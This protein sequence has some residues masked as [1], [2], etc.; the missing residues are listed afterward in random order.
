MD[1]TT[2]DPRTSGDSRRGGRP[3]AGTDPR[4]RRQ[5]MDGAGRVFSALGF[6]A[7]SMNDVAREAEVSKATLYV[8]FENKEQLFTAI[9]AER[10]DRNISDLI[11]YLDVSKPVDVALTEFCKEMLRRSSQ[12]FVIAAHRVVISVAERMPEIGREFYEA[13]P[14]RLA[15]ALADFIRSHVAAGHLHQVDDPHLAAAQFLELGQATVFR[16]RLYA[17]AREPASEEEI[18]I[19]SDGA[20]RLFLAAYGQAQ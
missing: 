16:K 17:I 11:G 14:K 19:A 2:L 12:P 5:I 9:C 10:R 3:A 13:G 20:V 7:A 15:S 18:R 6:D 1:Q 8:Y 4:K